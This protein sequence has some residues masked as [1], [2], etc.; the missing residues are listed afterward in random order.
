[1]THALVRRR[2][3]RL[4]PKVSTGAIGLVSLLALS[5]CAVGPNYKRPT[6]D[7]PPAFKE[8]EGWAPASPADTLDRGPWWTLF[9]D[10]D[11]DAL[12]AD[13]AAHNQSLAASLAAYRQ[14]RALVAEA[15]AAYY[16]T[17]NLGLSATQSGGGAR[18]V[19]TGT[20]GGTVSTGSYNTQSYA[21]SVGASWAPDLWGKVRRQVESAKATAQSDYATAMNVR[22]SLQTELASDYLQ[23]RATDEEIRIYEKTIQFYQQTQKISENQYKA[24][25]A[26]KNALLSA[27]SSVLDA[28]ATLASLRSTRQQYE[29]AVAV[30]AGRPPSELTLAPKPFELKIPDVPA[31]VPSDLLQRRPDIASAERLVK[32]AN[33]QVGVAVAAYYPTLTLSASYGFDAN[34]LGRIFNA[35]NNSWSVGATAAEPI[36]EGGL[37]GATVRAAKAARDE[38]VANYR[39]AV[40]TA[41]QQVEDQLAALR[42]LAEADA[43]ER[44]S[45]AAADEAEK[46]VANEY[47]AGT[48][49]PTDLLVAEQTAL[50]ERR[51]LITYQQQRLVAAVTLIEA[52]GGGWKDSELAKKD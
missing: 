30:L 20:G 36:F 42:Q 27:Q 46:I 14:A 13:V 32:S 41:F 4:S 35:S 5:A 34:N 26:A 44:Q 23:L 22:L 38:A 10:P 19:S 6:V 48:A 29:H 11:L 12:E 52:L 51:S 25:T 18:S 2:P 3:S 28:Q 37:R 50:N 9:G 24:G 1:M 21:P 49:A 33:A 45:S 15:R 16:P 47:K 17:L 40:L 31:G 39:Q 7:A 43:H 8:A